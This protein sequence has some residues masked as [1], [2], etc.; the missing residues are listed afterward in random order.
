MS[1]GPE[2][3]P[4]LRNPILTQQLLKLGYREI[5]R[6]PIGDEIERVSLTKDLGEYS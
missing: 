3:P 4:N 6:G 2:I 1:K 5:R